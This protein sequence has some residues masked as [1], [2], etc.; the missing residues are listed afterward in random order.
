M[1]TTLD[2]AYA[3]AEEQYAAL[4]VDVAAARQRLAEVSLSLHCWQGDDVAGFETPEASLSGGGIMVTGNYP[5]RARTPEELRADLE[6]AYSL[7][8]GRHRLNLHASYGE[9]GGR[10]VDRDQIEVRHY[11]GWMDWAKARGLGLDFNATC[12]SHPKTASGYTLSD[13]DA[14]VRGFWVE[15]VR[16][17]RAIGAAMGRALGRPCL[18]NLWIPDG[19]KE[20][21]ME[22][23]RHRELLRASLEE[24]YAPEYPA[25]ELRDAVE[26]KLF[27]IGSESYVVG[28]HEFYLG[29][30]LQHGL[31]VCLDLGHFHPTES[32]A[33]K[34]SALL[35]FCPEVLLH[36]SRGV[37]WDSDH[38]VI[39]NDELQALMQ[40][41]VRAGALDR[42]YLAT[43]YFDASINRVGAWVIGA[44]ATLKAL[45]RALLEPAE[46]LRA[47]EAAGDGFARLALLEE[48]KALPFGAVWDYHCAQ[49]GVPAGAAWVE[50][51]KDYEARVLRAR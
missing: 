28:S 50:V 35:T 19:A 42:V 39:L 29:Y 3:V 37:R 41:V 12:F 24:V 38:V 2:R 5:G 43:D 40:A 15:H 27:G 25:A 46:K 30:A 10:R 34:L 16:R 11:Q 44:R 20:V 22:A 48:A 13:T 45:L 6:V 23:A 36:V 17:C 49:S 1:N 51:V 21:P 8:P 9:F 14:S 31:V 33:D 26:S 47:A 18:H 4:G 32:I 7:L